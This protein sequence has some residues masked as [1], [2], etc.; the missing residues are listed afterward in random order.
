[1]LRKKVAQHHHQYSES[2]SS[3]L[4]WKSLAG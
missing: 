4:A 1:L 2:E 3:S